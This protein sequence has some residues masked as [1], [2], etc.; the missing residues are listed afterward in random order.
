MT[1]NTESDQ[2]E[3]EHGLLAALADLRDSPVGAVIYEQVRLIVEDQ[4]AALRNVD[5][6]YGMLLRLVLDAYARNPTFEHVREISDKLTELRR[7][8]AIAAPAP[9]LTL[10]PPAPAAPVETS[11]N[12]AWRAWLQSPAARA[13]RAATAPSSPEPAPPPVVPPP[14]QSTPPAAAPAGGDVNG[15]APPPQVERRVNAAYRLHLDRKRDEI[16]KLQE[17]F[18]Q[19]V[20]EAI[21]QNREFGALLQIELS[22]LKQAEGMQETETLRQILVGGI[23]ELIA[24]QRSLD[25]KLRRTSDYLQLIRTDSDRLRE[26]LNKVRLLSLTD[27]FTGLPNRRAFTRRL[28]D[29]IGR[30]QRYGLPLALALLDLDEFKLVNDAHGHAAGDE[31]LRCYANEV[32]SILRHHDLVARYGGEEFAVLL[33]NTALDGAMAALN[34]VK[35]RAHQV[36]CTLDGRSLPVPSFSAGLTLY[37]SGDQAST[38]ID[39]ADRALYRAKRLGRNRVESEVSMPTHDGQTDASPTPTP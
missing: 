9:A 11:P 4:D 38:L 26:E 13:A 37:V 24:G 18:A 16:A 30:A 27:E 29:E 12:T 21:A 35:Q 6:T 8:L 20:S 10:T 5:R 25:V 34:K 22:A 1:G 39:R 36:A 2:P 23:E 28:Q 32:L 14:T 19:N 7:T 31:V 33:P 15:I 17:A 3:A